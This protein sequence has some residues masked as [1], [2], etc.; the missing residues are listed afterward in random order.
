[1]RELN[2]LTIMARFLSTPLS[3]SR[4]P[5]WTLIIPRGDISITSAMVE[6]IIVEFSSRGVS[7][8][9]GQK[10]LTFTPKP[11]PSVRREVD[12]PTTACLV[13]A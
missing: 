1:M 3:R 10:T 11:A 2:G 5:S 13:A 7:I 4:T 6:L 12:S 8:T 9:P